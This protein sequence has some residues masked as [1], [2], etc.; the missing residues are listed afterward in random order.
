MSVPRD[1]IALSVAVFLVVLAIFLTP[2]N[3]GSDVP[4]PPVGLATHPLYPAFSAPEPGFTINGNLLSA[5]DDALYKTGYY[6]FN[7]SAWQSFTLSGTTLGGNWLTGT[8]TKTLPSFGSGEH[9]IVVYSCNHDSDSWDCYGNR[10]QLQI[11]NNA[12]TPLPTCSD[13][14]QNGAETGI[15]CGGSCDACATGRTFYVATNGNDNNP[16]TIDKPWATLHHA[17]QIL[18]PGDILYV[19]GGTYTN[20]RTRVFWTVSGTVAAPIVIRAFP[21]E[22]P[23]FDG[24]NNADHF[25]LIQAADF[26]TIDG[27][28]IK[29]YGTG[30]TGTSA[31][32][33]FWIGYSG[34]G[35][36]FAENIVLENLVIDNCG[37]NPHAHVIY[38]SYGVRN[39]T[40]RDNTLSMS[41]GGCIHQWHEPGVIGARVYNNILAHCHW[42]VI[43]ANGA[44]NVDIFNNVFYENENAMH[45]QYGGQCDHTT[46]D[47]SDYGVFNVNLR[48]NIVYQTGAQ[49]QYELLVSSKN[50]KRQSI[51]S[52]YNLFFVTS[53]VTVSWAD[54]NWN[55]P[56]FQANTSSDTH[57]LSGNPLF[58]YAPALISA[59]RKEALL[60]IKA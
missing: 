12:V 3:I 32:G 25:M 50:V 23:I 28:H 1:G 45:F 54:V 27:I 60:L 46:C 43:F 38:V 36:D 51:S 57:S 13:N 40:I 29:N 24:G 53:G 6:S 10:W 17:A 9:Y 26:L 14:K 4:L 16:G 44:T 2:A 20:H 47:D 55:L 30:S 48:N 37:S 11:I 41:F 21:G 35:D 58:L 56:G 31:A 49:S 18:S 15:D 19:R 7:G 8:A 33:C 34:E 39:I 59:F 42:G 22:I 5:S 52:D